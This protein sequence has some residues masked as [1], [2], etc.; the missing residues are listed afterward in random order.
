MGKQINPMAIAN[1]DSADDEMDLELEQQPG[2]HNHNPLFSST[3]GVKK[4]RRYAGYIQTSL[5]C[6]GRLSYRPLWK[7]TTKQCGPRRSEDFLFEARW[8]M[9]V[10]Q[11]AT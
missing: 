7:K 8:G 2:F 6:G 10:P 9:S 4:D 1:D 5:S 11:G 3:V